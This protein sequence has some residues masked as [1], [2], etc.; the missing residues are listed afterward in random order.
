[1]VLDGKKKS[2]WADMR[3]TLLESLNQLPDSGE[4]PE[5]RM[6]FLWN[7]TVGSEIATHTRVIRVTEKTLVVEVTGREWIQPLKSLE[8]KILVTLRDH[9]HPANLTRIRYHVNE[10]PWPAQKHGE[11]I[12]KPKPRKTLPTMTSIPPNTELKNI[13]DTELRATLSRLAGK[14]R[15]LSLLMV[16]VLISNCSSVN[17]AMSI[18]DEHTP[19][20]A[21]SF[22]VRQINALKGKNPENTYRDPRAYYNYLVALKSEREG[23]F[24][25]AALNYGRVVQFD[26]NR[27]NV[28]TRLVIL[29]L[30]IG[31]LEEAL[32]FGHDAL[33]RFP[34]NFKI[35]MVVGD[36]L[37]TQGK[38]REALEHYQHVIKRYP[39]GSRA[40]LMSGYSYL[41]LEDLDNA[42]ELFEKAV[43]IDPSNPMG[44]QYLGILMAKENNFEGA[45]E[46][47]RKAIKLRPSLI[48]A[49]QNLAR[50]LEQQD[51]YND[52]IQQYRIILKLDP[53]NRKIREHMEQVHLIVSSESATT[54]PSQKPKLPLMPW[55]E[56]DIHLVLGSLFYE[57]AIYLEA[58][59]EFRL[60]LAR[61]E[62]K[63]LRFVIAK[64]YELLGRMD[65]AI[66]EIENYRTG[67][68]DPV[69]VDVLL[70]LARLYGLNQE[71][72]KSITFL[73]QAVEMEKDNDR[74]YH[75]L[76]LAHMSLNQN[77]KAIENINTAISINDKRDSYFFEQGALLER[78]GKYDAAI[79]SMKQAL[80]INPNHSN[81]HNFIG[82]M[83][84][85]MGVDLDK[86]LDHLKQALV[87]QPRNGYF[88]DSLGW[89]YYKKGEPE[90]ALT[91][92]KRAMIFTEP[93]P[94]LYDHLGDVQFSLK[95]NDEAVR[96]WKTSLALTLKKLKDPSGEIPDPEKLRK[97]ISKANQGTKASF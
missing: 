17:Q 62:N 78:V 54:D 57:Q 27:E 90:K 26:P 86:A 24:E 9:L 46:K 82:Y 75:A 91:H 34:E 33:K 87:I 1:M 19:R 58:I 60:V 13:Q 66:Q 67:Q 80:A 16:S 22:A 42:R 47:F 76:A 4:P 41:G 56:T 36:I 5:D 68:T 85:T 43:L 12:S 8:R 71:M 63:D 61:Q 65:K 70:H 89:V 48:E 88:L 45:V 94:V 79:E 72:D 59:D 50:V 11:H 31:R 77:D 23:D 20:M 93:D 69:T 10:A 95:R 15:F 64:V 74:L 84:A 73:T 39:N 52:A 35:H 40:L 49:R 6:N 55:E 92:I 32:D 29:N 30:R 3:T 44:Y 38:Y 18:P 14:F 25:K 7:L 28:F 2:K 97:K 51:N 21:Q 83:Y 96:A 53:Q 81:A 37:T